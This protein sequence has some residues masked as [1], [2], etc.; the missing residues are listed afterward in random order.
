MSIVSVHVPAPYIDMLSMMALK[1]Y[2]LVDLLI[3]VFHSWSS[4]LYSC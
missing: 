4:L 3:V 2:S 1:I